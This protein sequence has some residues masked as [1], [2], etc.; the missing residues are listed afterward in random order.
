MSLN[1]RTFALACG[2][3]WGL[4]LFALLLVLWLA[5]NDGAPTVLSINGRAVLTYT[6]S[7]FACLLGLFGGFVDGVIGGAAFAWLYNR[8]AGR[9]AAS[10]A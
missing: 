8:I 6:L 2:L 3:A 7:P 9:S 5:G 1:V 10:G 4:F